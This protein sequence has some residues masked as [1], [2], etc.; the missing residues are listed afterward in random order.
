MRPNNMVLNYVVD[1][2]VKHERD[3]NNVFRA[4]CGDIRQT[5]PIRIGRHH[6]QFKKVHNY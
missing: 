1:R 5:G 4:T 3:S 6:C 2:K